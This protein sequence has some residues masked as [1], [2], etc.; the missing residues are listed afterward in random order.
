MG[1]KTGNFSNMLSENFDHLGIF[2]L[3]TS[4]R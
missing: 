1:G 2:T 4:L 3:A